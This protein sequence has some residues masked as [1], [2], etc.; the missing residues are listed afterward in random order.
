VLRAPELFLK[1]RLRE[2]FGV[3][4]LQIIGLFAE[5]DEFDG[6]SEFLLVS[7]PPNRDGKRR[8]QLK[9]P[10]AADVRRPSRLTK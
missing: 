1:Q 7:H 6:Q 9:I 10:V 8:L 2:L 3:E 5:A 4:G